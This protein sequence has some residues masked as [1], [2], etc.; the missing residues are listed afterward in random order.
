MMKYC[1]EVLYICLQLYILTKYSLSSL[2]SRP[3]HCT[4]VL[5]SIVQFV[6]FISLT[7][8]YIGWCT[9]ATHR[10]AT[11]RL[12]QTLQR[13]KRRSVNYRMTSVNMKMTPLPPRVE[14]CHPQ[15]T[16]SWRA[17]SNAGIMLKT[18]GG[19]NKQIFPKNYQIQNDCFFNIFFRGVLAW[20]GLTSKS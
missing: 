11:Q 16:Q 12:N 19:Q 1:R 2:Y 5:H 17:V 9:Q 15:C 7:Q 4:Q 3:A 14:R 10:T 6:T 18:R 8:A 13:T 20:L